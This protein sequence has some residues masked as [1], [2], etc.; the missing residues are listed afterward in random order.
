MGEKKKREKIWGKKRKGG[1]TPFFC[2]KQTKDVIFA[3]LKISYGELRSGTVSQAMQNLQTCLCELLTSLNL[4]FRPRAW[5]GQMRVC[6]TLIRQETRGKGMRVGM[7]RK[8]R[9]G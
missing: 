5:F 3:C 2:R 1:K 8:S 4:L 7:G 6:Q 9:E